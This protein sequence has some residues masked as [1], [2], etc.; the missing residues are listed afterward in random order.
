MHVYIEVSFGGGGLVAWKQVAEAPTRACKW[1]IGLHRTSEKLF[2]KARGVFV[3]SKE[4]KQI[5]F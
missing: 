2:N 5:V 4:S 3:A 1:V